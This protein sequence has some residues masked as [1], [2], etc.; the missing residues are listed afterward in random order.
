MAS[1]AYF[2]D[3]LIGDVIAAKRHTHWAI[4][5]IVEEMLVNKGAFVWYGMDW[6]GMVWYGMVFLK[7]TL[8]CKTT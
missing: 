1:V 8:Q 4:V 2:G 6:Y 5:A 3:H 7:Y